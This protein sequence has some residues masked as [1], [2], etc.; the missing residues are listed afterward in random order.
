MRDMAFFDPVEQVPVLWRG[1]EYPVPTFYYDLTSVMVHF[2]TPAAKLNALLPSDR[3][4]P[5]RIVPGK[6]VT[7]IS[8]Y[9][10]RDS[11]IGPYN[12]MLLGFPV[13]IDHP[14]PMGIGLRI[15]ERSG[16]AAYVWQLPVTT[17]IA[18]DMGIDVGGYPKILADISFQS[19]AGWLRCHARADG[20]DIVALSIRRPRTKLVNR[21]WPVDAITV[22]DRQVQRI[23]AIVNLRRLGGSWMPSHARLDIGTHPIGNELSELGLGRV[24]AIRYAPDSQIILSRPI[25]GWPSSQPV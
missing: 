24:L 18:R 12:E 8:F 14:A 15:A 5:M 11:D 17:E 25:E 20:Q 1:Q 16:V 22:R 10:Y 23:P 13:T 4:H 2:L 6:A 3:L 7:S 21:R 9:E 19:D